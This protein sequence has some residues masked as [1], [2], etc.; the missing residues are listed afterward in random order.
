MPS[1]NRT[2]KHGI[3]EPSR[4]LDGVRGCRYPPVGPLAQLAEQRAFNPKVVGS[5]PTRPTTSTHPG[6]RALASGQS[7]EEHQLVYGTLRARDAALSSNGQ[8]TGLSSRQ[9]GFDSRQGRHDQ[10]SVRERSVLSTAAVARGSTTFGAPSS[11]LFLFSFALSPVPLPLF[12]PGLSN[13]L[14]KPRLPM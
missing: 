4:R 7:R 6:V 13:Q 1:P 3:C 2:D 5:I 12:C 10:S 11:E 14:Q 9:H 8:D